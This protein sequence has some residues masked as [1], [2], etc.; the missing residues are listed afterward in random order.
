MLQP[1][2]QSIRR[3]IM[4]K[5]MISITRNP[6]LGTTIVL[7]SPISRRWIANLTIAPRRYPLEINTGYGYVVAKAGMIL[8]LLSLVVLTCTGCTANPT[9]PDAPISTVPVV[10]DRPSVYATPAWDTLPSD[11]QTAI[12]SMRYVAESLETFANCWY[13]VSDVK[14]S[15][16]FNGKRYSL[17]TRSR[18]RSV[19]ESEVFGDTHA[20]GAVTLI[21]EGFFYDTKTDSLYVLNR[22]GFTRADYENGVR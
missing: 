21:K 2:P 3:Y 22:C 20:E 16:A 5:P 4:P 11:T 14:D 1:I 17:S 7:R 8:T 12:T 9:A 18:F 15:L 6:M 19:K 10:K 13:P